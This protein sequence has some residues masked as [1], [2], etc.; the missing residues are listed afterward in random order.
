MEMC[1]EGDGYE[2]AA[3]ETQGKLPKSLADETN[4]AIEQGALDLIP[5][6]KPLGSHPLKSYD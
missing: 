1:N 4:I 6:C 3:E 2:Q 5:R